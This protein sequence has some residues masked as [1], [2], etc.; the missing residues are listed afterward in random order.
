MAAIGTLVF[1]TDCGNLL[2][3]TKGTQRN[4]LSCECCGAENRD[5][6]AKVT[7]AQTKP[8]D[9]PSF[10]RQKLQSSVQAVEKHNLQTESTAHEKCPKCGREEVK[11]T[12]V[13]LRGADEGSTVIYLCECGYSWHE[14]N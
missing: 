2:P 7:V 14:N 5:T 11:Y 12:N 10:L 9:F 1:C 8:S 13:Q 3:A 4:V 6:G